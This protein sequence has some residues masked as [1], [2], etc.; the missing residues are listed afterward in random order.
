M[1]TRCPACDTTF[2]V[3]G[4]VLRVARGRVRC[5][6]CATTF[7]AIAGLLDENA[8]EIATST[9]RDQE[10]TPA[11]EGTSDG[12]GSADPARAATD[13]PGREQFLTE[14]ELARIFVA[15][16]GW[17]PHEDSPSRQS[18]AEDAGPGHDRDRDSDIVVDERDAYEEITLEGRRIEISGQYPTISEEDGWEETLQVEYLPADEEEE[19]LPPLRQPMAAPPMEQSSPASPTAAIGSQPASDGSS[20]DRVAQDARS[21]EHVIPARSGQ[22]ASGTFRSAPTSTRLDDSD[23]EDFAPL[24]TT[25][26]RQRRVAMW[27]I[28][29]LLLSGTLFGQVVHH[30][31]QDLVRHPQLGPALKG[32]YERLGMPLAPNWDLSGY[33]LQQWGAASDPATAGVLRV[34]ASISNRAEFA[35]PYPLLR[36]V[37]EDLWGAKVGVREFV[38]GDYLPA[39]TSADRLMAP[40]QRTNAELAIVDPGADAVGF[41]LDICLRDSSGLRCAAEG[42]I[43]N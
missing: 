27:S 19:V 4:A 29:S 35:Q 20:D 14:E 34:R 39:G 30:Y 10:Q 2:R 26:P 41:R 36:L 24:E 23:E 1:L 9:A 43:G 12:E 38:P 7:D 13:E 5:G 33:E 42:R 18:V 31:R 32:T 25:A 28:A 11:S 16:P 6:R 37:L 8:A 22:S 21:T 40:G 3:T 17:P 15:A